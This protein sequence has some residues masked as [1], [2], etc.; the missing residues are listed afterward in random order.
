MSDWAALLRL[1][2]VRLH[3]A[4]E[5]FWRLSV[6]EWA[7]LTAAPPSMA[8]GRRD[9]DALMAAHPDS[10]SG[11]AAAPLTL[12]RSCRSAGPSLF[13]EGRGVIALQ[14]PLPSGERAG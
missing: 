4:P 6:K 1:A 10:R 14:K 9:L 12:P 13:P 11:F 8:L 7:A 5:A 2:A 3:I